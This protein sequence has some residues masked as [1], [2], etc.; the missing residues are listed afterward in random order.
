MRR[1]LSSTV[2]LGSLLL[3]QTALAQ[4]SEPVPPAPTT[5]AT[6]PTPTATEP[7]NAP[8]ALPAPEAVPAPT[9]APEEDAPTSFGV[10]F[11][12]PPRPAPVGR[13]APATEAASHGEGYVRAGLEV[14][15]LYRFRQTRTTAGNSEW[16]HEFDVPRVHAA[17][18]G[19]NATLRGRVL[20]EATRSA[21]EGSLIGVAGDS[22]VLR[23]REAYGAFRPVTWASFDAGMVPTLTIPELDG[24]WMTRAVAPSALEASGLSSPA[25]L[26]ARAHVHLPRRFGWV[27]VAAYNGEGYR[28]RELN[29]GK[30]LEAAFEIHPVPHRSLV[31][32]GI[33]G[34][35]TAGSA[36]TGRARADR[37]TGGLVW[38]DARVR[39]GAV[40]TWAHGFALDGAQRSWVLSAFARVEPVARLLLS[41]RVDHV[42]RD[43]TADTP[44]DLSTLIG[45]VGWRAADSLEGF[46]AFTRSLPSARA[47]SELPGSD[48]WTLSLIAR[49]VY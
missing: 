2:I 9:P 47:E 1:R 12:P 43:A 7:T 15:A 23:V 41:A 19:G 17:V 30:N 8:A 42:I 24:T 26:G 16:F 34:S 21:S 49:V 46:L 48:N 32:L 4:P 40:V 5:S 6:T 29:R 35:Y 33:F 14:F 44:S 3:G 27:A 31:P 38:Q 39:A 37:A 45:A 18:E 25:D 22:L 20:V 13:A 11:L 28:S 10:S 36:G